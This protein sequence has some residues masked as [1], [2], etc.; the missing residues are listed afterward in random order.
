MPRRIPELLRVDPPGFD[1]AGTDPGTTPGVAGR[2]KAQARMVR[3]QA[4]LRRL[5]ERWYAE[6]RRSL[7]VVLQG[8]D[9]SGKDGTIK[10]V[11]TGV[12]PQGVSITSFKA[13]TEQ[14]R[15][16]DFL[17]PV[18]PRLPAPGVIGLFN[19]SH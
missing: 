5:Q 9:T 10:H 1:P 7:L 16:H 13:P 4:R 2:R 11:F 15:R 8:M 3:G 17:W 14:E 12:N 19:R 18:R 6:G